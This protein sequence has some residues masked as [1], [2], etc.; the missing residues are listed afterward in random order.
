MMSPKLLQ[1]GGQGGSLGGTPSR[2]GPFAWS[3]KPV[4]LVAALALSACAQQEEATPESQK[5]S[6]P[7]P[8]REPPPGPSPASSPGTV[9]RPPA[10]ITR[11]V[12]AQ[13]AA[14]PRSAE[15][16]ADLARRYFALLGARNFVEAHKLWGPGS[17]LADGTFAAQFEGYRE[18]RGEVG[19]PSAVEGAAG[20]LF[21][22]VP[23]RV[24]G[25]AARG[26]RFEETQVV[27]LRRVNDVPGSTPEQRRWH[28]A[29]VDR[30]PG[31][32]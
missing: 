9:T 2:V 6:A 17:D 16:A 24:H 22:T 30:P 13:A 19:S 32:H 25:V 26:E 29:K 3:M 14:D 20:S 15:G 10:S 8:S 31:P 1:K 5:T 11:N 18:L 27:T 4:V 7:L 28:I 23:A 21:V 12:P